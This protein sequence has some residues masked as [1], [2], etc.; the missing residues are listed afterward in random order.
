MKLRAF[1]AVCAGAGL[2]ALVLSRC[3]INLAN[4]HVVATHEQTLPVPG[5]AAPP[6]AALPAATTKQV[7]QGY[8]KLPLSFEANQGQT[9]RQVRFLSRGRGYAFFLTP[10]E[11]LLSLSKPA[12]S[13]AKQAQQSSVGGSGARLGRA[14]SPSD[15]MLR[16][17]LEGANPAAH[18]KGLEQL[19]GKVNYFLGNDPGKWRTNVPTYAAVKVH[20]IYPGIDV[21][22]YGNQRQ[23][24]SDFVVA[25]G[26]D[27]K[28]I[29]LR[30]RGS[31]KLEVDANGDLV[32]HLKDG[33][34]RQKKPFIYQEADG[35]RQEISGG[36]LL[37]SNDRVAF[38]LG[39]YD[40]SRP[41][42]I[43]P[44]LVYSTFLGGSD[45]DDAFAIAVDSSRNAFV[46]GFTLSTNF[47]TTA[48]AFQTTSGGAGDVF[49]TKLNSTGST[50]LYSTYLGG[51]NLDLATAIVVDSAGNAFVAGTT[52]STDFPTTTGA[53]QTTF[54]GGPGDAF[55]AKLNPSGSVLVYSTYLGGNN[56]DQGLGLSLDSSGNAYVTGLSASTNFPT[57]TG[58]FQTTFSGSSQNAFVTKLNP[59]GSALVY[60][61]YLGGTGGDFGRA[62]AVDPS[63]DAY[64]TGTTKSSD[65]PT[66][67]GS[68]QTVFSGFQDAFVTKLNPSGSALIY[69]TYLG[70]SNDLGV[71][72]GIALDTS[73]DA[74][75]T[76]FTASSNFPTTSG[77]FQTTFGGDLLDAFVTK[78]NSAGSAL[79]YST[80]LGG[81]GFDE[82]FGIAVD[83]TGSAY[84][85]GFTTSTNFPTA[86]A[87]QTTSGGGDDVFVTKLN[88]AGSALVY[89]TYL[90]ASGDDD[91]LGIAI[92]SDGSAYVVG[93]TA[94]TGF[95]ITTG[96]FQTTLGGGFSDAFVAKISQVFLGSGSFVIGDLNAVPGNTVTF[97]GAQWATANSLSGG[98]APSNFKGFVST[99]PQT[100]GGAW[101]SN[102]ANSSNPPGTVPGLMAVIASSSTTTSGSVISG[103]VPKI[104]LVETNP[105][106]GPAPGQAGTGT[107]VGVL[108][109]H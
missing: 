89:S 65:F 98:T 41:L 59:A 35:H 105:G 86:A 104:V 72:D 66:V 73:G 36:Y 14:P 42:I 5:G 25:P 68:F 90:G 34:I 31:D 60:S 50:L 75:V 57:T 101:T 3:G 63:G 64:V 15:V 51:S 27:P 37:E 1:L 39:A 18:V 76:G 93:R 100:C 26:V 19:P 102:P 78:L 106:Y 40:V 52:L 99:A 62:V 54:G 17:K 2:L 8:G 4:D 81:S 22:Y 94:S 32:A 48:G 30:F 80:F 92:D 95:P 6:L 67:S 9:D 21:S 43:D 103:N 53:F 61:T 77:A 24:E 23:L 88:P 71:G 20:D 69:S 47:P 97:W 38:Q 91:G 79:V 84:V 10:T 11:T 109:G 33:E 45:R 108:C 55:V 13:A 58:A 82:A 96:A 56:E 83:S 87:I 74:Y 12:S 16:I 70:G 44:V 85:T 46:T 7:L 107:V 29:V 49:V 28:A